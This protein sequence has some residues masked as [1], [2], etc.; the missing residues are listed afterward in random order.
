VSFTVQAAPDVAVRLGDT[1][2]FG[3]EP[4]R[5]YLFDAENRNT[6]ARI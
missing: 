6:F 2:Q 1:L 3:L 5:L 4:G